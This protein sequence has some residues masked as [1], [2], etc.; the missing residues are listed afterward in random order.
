MK[1]LP[2]LVTPRPRKLTAKSVNEERGAGI[3]WDVTSRGRDVKAEGGSLECVWVFCFVV[4]F[5]KKRKEKKKRFFISVVNRGR[6]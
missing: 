6:G 3:D 1:S 5:C 2:V 4:V